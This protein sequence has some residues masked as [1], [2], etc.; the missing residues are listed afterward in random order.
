MFL[1]GGGILSHGVPP[2]HHAIEAHR[3]RRR[4]SVG[5]I[6]GVLTVL[7][8]TLLDGLVGI[9]AGAIVL[10]GVLAGRRVVRR[11][12]GDAADLS[13]QGSPKA[14]LRSVY[15]SDSIRS[16]YS[17]IASSLDLPLQAVPGVPL[18]AARP[19]RRSRAACRRRRRSVACL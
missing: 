16:T 8:S 12:E 6:G 11:Q 13:R 3:R 19:C 10:G 18:G 2:L 5:G 17:C 9:A 1:V 4:R 14:T 7:V 15:F